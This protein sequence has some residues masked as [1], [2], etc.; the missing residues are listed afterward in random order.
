MAYTCI[1]FF[2]SLL[3]EFQLI[4]FKF[5]SGSL[6]SRTILRLSQQQINIRMEQQ[7]QQQE[8]NIQEAASTKR[9]ANISFIKNIEY[10]Y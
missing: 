3:F 1:Y 6:Q 8:S 7:Q 9:N 4:S 2:L 5:R 10:M